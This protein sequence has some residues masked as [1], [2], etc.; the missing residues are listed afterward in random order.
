M[1]VRELLDDHVFACVDR[2]M[3]FQEVIGDSGSYQVDL[4]EGRVRFTTGLDLGVGLLGSAAPGPR[5]WL[6]AWANPTAYSPEVLAVAEQVR[7]FGEQHGVRELVTA[8]VPLDDAWDATRAGIASV[9]ASDVDVW[10]PVEAGGG[11][12]VMLAVTEHPPLPAPSPEPTRLGPVLNQVITLGVVTD[13][14][15]ALRAYA[16]FRGGELTEDGDHLELTPAGGDSG[17]R[18]ELGADGRPAS[19]EMTRAAG[20]H[21]L[22]DEQP[23]APAKKRLFGRLFGR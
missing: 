7:A 23:T 16:A 17:A 3:A 6:W 14:R 22:P 15:R 12:Q 19:L 8:E 18:L 5:S 1:D 21:R 10:L 13:W 11:T 4:H 9:A 2:Q 20:P